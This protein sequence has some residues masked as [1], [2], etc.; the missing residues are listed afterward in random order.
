MQ[1]SSLSMVLFHVQVC[2]VFSRAGWLAELEDANVVV[3]HGFISRASVLG[4][5]WRIGLAG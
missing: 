2:Y 3:K 5:T 4:V 1:M